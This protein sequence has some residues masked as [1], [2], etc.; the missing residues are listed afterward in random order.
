MKQHFTHR[1][2]MLWKI[3]DLSLKKEKKTKQEGNVTIGIN[4]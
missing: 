1:V 2:G 3:L 4:A